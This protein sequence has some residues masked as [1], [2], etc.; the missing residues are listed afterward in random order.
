MRRIAFV[1]ICAWVLALGGFG[2][3]A[4]A[5]GSRNGHGWYSSCCY[6]K[7]FDD[8]GRVRTDKYHPYY[9]YYTQPHVYVR[10]VGRHQVVRQTEHY[11][12]GTGAYIALGERCTTQKVRLAE[13]GGGWRWGVKTVCY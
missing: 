13:W 9:I 6:P 3:P 5:S 2:G 11:Y 10:T 4:K 1:M 12:S 7:P 8:G